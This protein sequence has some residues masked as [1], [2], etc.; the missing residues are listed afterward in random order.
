MQADAAEYFLKSLGVFFSTDI[1][2]EICADLL[3]DNFRINYIVFLFFSGLSS[4]NG[5]I[6]RVI[7][8]ISD[9]F[10]LN[11]GLNKVGPQLGPIFEASKLI[12]FTFTIIVYA[13]HCEGE[14]R[15]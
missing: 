11:Y 3:L 13:S 15:E 5:L 1:D 2:V 9:F 7:Y 12:S 10:L 14:K 6:L 8:N 4:G